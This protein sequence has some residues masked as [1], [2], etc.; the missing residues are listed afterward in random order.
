VRSAAAVAALIATT[1]VGCGGGGFSLEPGDCVR[2]AEEPGPD[3]MAEATIVDC[4]QPHQ[5]EVFHVF[6]LAPGQ[7]EGEAL[8]DAVREACLGEAFT[9]YVGVPE[10][11]SPLEVLPLPPTEGEIARGDA[12]VVCTLREPGGGVRTGALRAGADLGG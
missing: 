1:A 8:V 5:L 9:D 2:T 7:T 4:D 10:D 12:E 11:R 6:E 3:G